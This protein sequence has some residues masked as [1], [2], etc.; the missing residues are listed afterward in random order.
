MIVRTLQC[1]FLAGL[2]NLEKLS[3]CSDNLKVWN[4]SPVHIVLFGEHIGLFR[5]L[6]T[7][8]WLLVISFLQLFWFRAAAGL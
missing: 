5:D 7:A 6:F 2:K 3:A 8:P 1:L 4:T